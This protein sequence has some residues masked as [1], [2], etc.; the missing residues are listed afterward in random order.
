MI[1]SFKNI[2]CPE[3]KA[4]FNAQFKKVVAQYIVVVVV[5]LVEKES[6][7]NMCGVDASEEAIILF[8]EHERWILKSSIGE[9]QDTITKEDGKLE[10][11]NKMLGVDCCSG[12][13][14]VCL[15]K[16]YFPQHDT[17]SLKLKML[18]CC[19]VLEFY[20]D[21]TCFILIQ[22]C[23]IMMKVNNENLRSNS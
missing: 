8:P 16:P 7:G 19:E 21:S 10:Q 13:P 2:D 3:K 14:E 17:R 11:A 23:G 4:F 12:K 6:F 15:R 5:P 22:C 18:S 1:L 9:W 20:L